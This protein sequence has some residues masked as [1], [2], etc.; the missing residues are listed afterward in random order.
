MGEGPSGGGG[1]GATV[2]GNITP[3]SERR[4]RRKAKHETLHDAD[5]G[6]IVVLPSVIFWCVWMLFPLEAIFAI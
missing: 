6:T 5:E 3:M 2:P 4:R 1:N